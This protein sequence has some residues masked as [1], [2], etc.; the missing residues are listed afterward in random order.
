[1]KRA[2]IIAL[3]VSN[4]LSLSA[5]DFVFKIEPTVMFP[6]VTQPNMQVAPGVTVQADLD[7]I[8][9]LTAGVEGGYLFEQ[10]KATDDGINTIFGGLNLGVYYYPIS[11]LYLGAG[12]GF[13]I[14]SI[15]TQVQKLDSE[16]A[17]EKK[18]LNGLY[19]RG[20]GEVG[21][22]IN[23][24]LCINL[25]GG[26]SSYAAGTALGQGFISG[27]F[28]ALS[29][30]MNGHV[31]T[32]GKSSAI[33]VRINQDFDV[34]P[35][36]STVYG[37]EPFGT[38]Y[39][40]NDE[41]A[42]LRD[43]H[44][45]FRAGKYT[46]SAKLCGTVS[47][48]N[49]HT[50]VEFPL[51][52]DFSDE[53]LGFTEDGKI[54]GEIVIEYEFLGKKMSVTEP[55]IV[56]VCNRNAF[57]WGDSSALAAFISPDSQ[58]I[59][60]FAKEVAGITRNNIYTGMNA[61]LQYAIGIIEGLRLIGMGYSED[62][63]TP[64]ATY[65]LDTEMDSIQYPLQTLQCLSGDYDDLGILVC[66]CLQTIN[67]PTGYIPYD[68]DFIV[69]VKLN[70]GANQALNN[71]ASTDGLV[72]DYDADEV[73][74]ALSMKAL[75]KGFTASYKAGAD[76]VEKIF[77]NEDAYYDFIDTTDAWTS[78][79]P[80]AFSTN[81]SVTTPKQDALVKNIKSAIQDYI[82]SDIEAVIKRAREAG[83]S[84]KLGVALVRAGRYS[85]AKRE[86]Q[87]AADKGSISAMNNVAN[88][89]MIEKNYTAAAAQYKAILQK[90]P[91]NK[92]AQKG[93]ENANAKIE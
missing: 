50:T 21:F 82:A 58:E 17:T 57:V 49:R 45:S 73:Y 23:P 41:G 89:L 92:T 47:K 26:W 48:I 83:D 64:Y 51:I 69:L 8:N 88:I 43:V 93:L 39:V 68:D 84:N 14:H 10:P 87:K 29:L 30:R 24:S 80:V 65:H 9:L 12:A 72:I 15:M 56:S 22:R 63:T 59:A 32:N 11:R 91:S 52:A 85:E 2:A 6:S 71:F 74:L 67:V 42:E 55:V 62:N 34:F 5:L 18:T 1:M 7:F 81:S 16:E 76:V 90:D 40:K 28:A 20:F 4:M 75:D 86:F 19:Y 61:N 70:M 33:D 13:G 25:A 3:L 77:S 36:Y 31:G 53:I 38:I 78:Y 54:S 60:T 66:S 79:K 46:N 35:V 27:P 44:V 37:Y